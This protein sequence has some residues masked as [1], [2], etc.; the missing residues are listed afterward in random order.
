MSHP[1]NYLVLMCLKVI[2]QISKIF[3]HPGFLTLN[4]NA[5]S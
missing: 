4:I 3:L 1:T 2:L 5:V